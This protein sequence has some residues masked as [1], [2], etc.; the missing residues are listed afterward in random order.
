MR[1]I[2]IILSWKDNERSWPLP[3]ILPGV[4]FCE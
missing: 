2:G 4:T 3:V 1:F